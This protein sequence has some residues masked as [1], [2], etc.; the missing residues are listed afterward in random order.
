[1]TSSKPFDPAWVSP[2]GDTV[3]DLLE[4]RAWTSV[5]LAERLGVTPKYVSELLHGK[6]TISAE[7]AEKLS[8]VLGSTAEFWLTREARYRSGLQRQESDA[9]LKEDAGWLSELPTAWMVKAG[10]MAKANTRG[11]QVREALGYFNVASVATW[12]D[13]YSGQGAAF[14]SSAKFG[15]KQGAVAAWLRAAELAAEKVV[16]APWDEQAFRGLLP[17]LRS[18]TREPDPK[19]FVAEVQRLCAAVGVAVVFVPAPPGCPISGATRWLSPEKALL[20]LSL[21]HNTNDHLWFTFFHEAGHLLLH[22]KKLAFVEGMDGLDPE[23]EEDANRFAGELLIPKREALRLRVMHSKAEVES[24]ARQIGVHAGIVVG[25]MQHDKII[26]V[27]W[28]NDLKQHY[29]WAEA[30]RG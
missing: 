21:R 10:L 17:S 27:T 29:T 15:K 7:M 20:V 12:R 22:G 24:F 18:L 11:G 30:E 26:D 5:V 28:M 16:C 1:M 2:P 8:L 13:V 4:E 14:R 6:A 23:L 19:V 25:R 9:A 3:L